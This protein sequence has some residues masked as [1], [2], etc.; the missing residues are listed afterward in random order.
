MKSPSLLSKI[1]VLVY[2]CDGVL[3]DNKVT[4]DEKGHEYVSFNRGDG[5]AISKISQIPLVQLV[6]STEVNPIVTKRCQKLK[7]PVYNGV[8]DKKS[9]L[10]NYCVSNHIMPENVM[11]IG[12]DLNDLEC[13]KYVGVRG[14]PLDA[15]PE[16]KDICQWIS[17]KNG[18][19]GVIRDL[20]RDLLKSRGDHR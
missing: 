11:F 8:D 6:I 13:M 12:N 19:D 9:V 20:Y 4:V 3:T 14:C 10:H 17:N 1:C 18:G 5:F 16:I 15:E 2:D 7:I